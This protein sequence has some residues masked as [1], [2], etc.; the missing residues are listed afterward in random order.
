MLVSNV[1][2]TDAD[3]LDTW[4]CRSQDG[5]N[6]INSYIQNKEGRNLKYSYVS[7]NRGLRGFNENETDY[8]FGKFLCKISN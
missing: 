3:P 2:G 4:S 7:D 6:L 5:R 8:L 1:T